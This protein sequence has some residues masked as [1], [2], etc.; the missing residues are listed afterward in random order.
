MKLYLSKER[1]YTHKGIRLSI[2]PQVFHPAFFFSTRFLLSYL[3]QKQLHGK[4]FLELG[5]G[6]GLIS[7]SAAKAGAIVT[8]TD[9]N[10]TAIEYL[11]KN[12]E[13]NQIPL[14]II[15]SDLFNNIPLQKFDIIAINPPY[16]KKAPTTEASYAW[17]CGENGEY[18]SRLFAQ[19]NTYLS[20]TS[21][22]Y[23][24]LCDDCDL[25][26]IQRIAGDNGFS[27][28]LVSSAKKLWE[29]NLIYRIFKN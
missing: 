11:H 13:R 22:V 5:A 25:D 28:S 27:F 16:Y 6:S 15:S 7:L 9:I 8:S 18:F 20:A 19:I 2:P 17:Y 21:E 1:Q 14:T 26:M 29:V 3:L 12:S 4:T 23:M 10:Q 24:V